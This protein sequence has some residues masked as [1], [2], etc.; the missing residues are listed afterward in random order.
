MCGCESWTIKKAECWRID[1][2][3]LWCWRL[4]RKEIKPVNPKGNQSWIFFGKTDAKAPVLWPTDVKR[5][6]IR[7]DPDA[8]KDWKQEDKGDERGWDG[9]MASLTQWT[10]VWASFRR[11]WRTE[12]TGGCS[13]WGCKYSDMTERLNNKTPEMVLKTLFDP[14]SAQPCD[15]W[16]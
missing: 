8:G 10:R 1:V 13:P 4:D 16:S 3:E 2:F 11:W 5:R 6:L 14:I 7:K 12:K 15:F 9:W